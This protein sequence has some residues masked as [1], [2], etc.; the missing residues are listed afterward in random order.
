MPD[1]RVASLSVFFPAFNEQDIIAKTVENASRAVAQLADDYEIIVVNDGSGDRTAAVVEDIARR[2]ARVRLVSH[3]VNLGYGAAL[4]TGFA[5]ASKE[6]VF[7]SDADGQFDLAEL[8]GLLPMLKR[9]PVVLG[10][11]IRRSDP[12]YRLF[13]AKVYNIVIRLTFGL[14]VRDIDCAFKLFRRSVLEGIVL[15]SDGAFISS[16]LLIKLRRKDVP[17]VERGVHHYPRT[18][19]G[20]KGATPAVIL[21]TIQD[22]ARLRMGRPLKTPS[23]AAEVPERFVPPASPEDP[24]ASKR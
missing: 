19:G 10:Y 23:S 18:T 21:K 24:V 6:L 8:H 2:D 20:S 16:E 12:L 3:P 17:M 13:I 22:V 14:R 11:R 9:A 7:F 4:R 1:D 15:E 5:S